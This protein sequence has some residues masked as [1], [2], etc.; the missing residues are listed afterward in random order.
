[1]KTCPRCQLEKNFSKF[2]KDSKR[3]DGLSRT[4]GE[5]NKELTYMCR[6]RKK[7]GLPKLRDSRCKHG[8]RP[9]HKNYY[10]ICQRYHKFGITAEEFK[11]IFEKQEGCCAICGR[12]QLE[13]KK[14]LAVDHC[15]KTGKIRGLLCTNCNQGLG[16][17]MDNSELLLK[18]AEYLKDNI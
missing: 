16:H 11:S 3:K 6:K 8:V 1:M 10:S 7:Q 5:C 4:C 9:D 17:F 2:Y 18:A 13:F 12:H 15:H 14:A